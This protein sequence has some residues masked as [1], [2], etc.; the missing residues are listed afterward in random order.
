MIINLS[1]D[2]DIKKL[3]DFVLKA[4]DQS[5]EVKIHK[6]TRTNRQNRAIWLYCTLL[7]EA[8]NEAGIYMVLF[9]Y[10]EGAQVSWTK[11][12]VMEALWRP[13]QIAMFNI[14]STTKLKTNEVSQVYE[15]INRF[16]GE[17]FGVSLSFPNYD[18]MGYK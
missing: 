3:I 13:V 9:F 1:K 14:R 16:T 2:N 7:A 12:S 11:E 4:K 8:F 6:H 5:I 17:K 18:Y 15:D 10:K